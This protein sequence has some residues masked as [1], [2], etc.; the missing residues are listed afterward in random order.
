M[1]DVI[2]RKT[3]SIRICFVSVII[4]SV[5]VKLKSKDK[6]SY[7]ELL[8]IYQKLYLVSEIKRA[9]FRIQK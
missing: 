9:R 6:H 5:F 8:A 4:V 3:Q 2:N 1:F 7:W